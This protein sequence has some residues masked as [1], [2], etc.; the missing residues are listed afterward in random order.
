MK[1]EICGKRDAKVAVNKLVDG[2]QKELY[3]CEECAGK[4]SGGG[5]NDGADDII[6][7]VDAN[8]IRAALPSPEEV[9]GGLIKGIFEAGMAVA[10]ALE[11]PT[12][13]EYSSPCPTCGI[14]AEEFHRST[15]LGCPDCYKHFALAPIIKGMHPGLAHVGKSPEA[16]Q[17]GVTDK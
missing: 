5:A 8:A 10:N 16:S 17:D 15:R 13:G 3:V 4:T 11:N 6:A 9:L 2:T 14:T 7:T 12:G 1:C